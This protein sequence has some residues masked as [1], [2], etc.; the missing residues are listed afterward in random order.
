MGEVPR[1]PRE[2][3]P[4]GVHHVYARGND[5]RLIYLDDADRWTYLALLGRVG[6]RMRWRVL[7]YCLMDNHVHLLVETPEA[8]LGA[9][10]QRL[11]GAYAQIF[12]ARHGRD[13]HVFQGR[14]NAVPARD[15]GQL[16]LAAAYI[17]RN[18]VA[19]GLT[20]RPDGWTWSSHGALASDG[21]AP[22]WLDHDRLLAYFGGLGGDPAAR[23]AEA[24]EP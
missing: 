10:M 22:G 21:G 15:D 8:N 24:V 17:A 2:E 23:Y 14:F 3:I 20:S 16:W 19:A 9:G 1:K 7:A 5:R 12:N 4:G 11:H 13:G 6:R 18:P